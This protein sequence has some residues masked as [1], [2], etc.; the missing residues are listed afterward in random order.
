MI[1]YTVHTPLL[2]TALYD[3]YIQYN[4]SSILNQILLI[5]N[6]IKALVGWKACCLRK[7]YPWNGFG[8]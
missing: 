8:L 2:Y 6:L 3:I 4:I 5:M 1:Q 7:G